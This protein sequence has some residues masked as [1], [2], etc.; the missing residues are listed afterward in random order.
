MLSGLTCSMA[1]ETKNPSRTVPRVMWA[2]TILHFTMVYVAVTMFIVIVI[3]FS[4]GNGVI[5]PVVSNA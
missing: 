3:P 4:Q 1:E 2:T 5:S